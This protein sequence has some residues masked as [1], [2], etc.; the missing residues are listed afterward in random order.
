MWPA[1]KKIFDFIEVP[2]GA[3]DS[4]FTILQ[5]KLIDLFSEGEDLSNALKEL[6]KWCC[7]ILEYIHSYFFGA[8]SLGDYLGWPTNPDWSAYYNAFY[9]YV[10]NPDRVTTPETPDFSIPSFSQIPLNFMPFRAAYICWYWNYRDQLLEAD[11]YDPE[12]DDFQSDIVTPLQAVL[13]FLLR[14]RC[15]YKD[16]YTTALTNTGDGN[17]RVPIAD[18]SALSPSG[19]NIK[20][21]DGSGALVQTTDAAAA[22]EAGATIMEIEIGSITYK[23]PINY[24]GVATN[25]LSASTTTADASVV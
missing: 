21:F 16:T 12:T 25:E 10:S 22:Q 7:D 19:T 5:T 24:L 2:S 18:G 13:C 8:S 20:Y 14:I 11:A 17:F 6:I 3:T 15:W 4:V 1:R 23:M 9:E